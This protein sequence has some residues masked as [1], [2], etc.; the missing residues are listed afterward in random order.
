MYC[1][2]YFVNKLEK[3][4]SD[5][6]SN[7]DIIAR[8]IASLA[9]DDS[10]DDLR[11]GSQSDNPRYTLYHTL[12][13]YLVLFGLPEKEDM[14][15]AFPDNPV[16]RLL[17]RTFTVPTKKR[18]DSEREAR[19]ACVNQLNAD[20]ARYSLGRGTCPAMARARQVMHQLPGAEELLRGMCSFD[21]S[22]RISMHSALQSRFF[23]KLQAPADARTLRSQFL[24]HEFSHYRAPQVQTLPI[25]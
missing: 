19:V 14:L 17:Y 4:W 3:I 21:P 15:D 5:T 16:V 12:Y 11:M 8:V 9:D 10:E 13:R 24:V 23:D 7:Y 20:Q 18:N 6:N 2:D 1:P 25:L 22:K